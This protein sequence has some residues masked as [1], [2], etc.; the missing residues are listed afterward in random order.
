MHFLPPVQVLY[1]VLPVQYYGLEKWE[2]A[3]HRPFEVF[4]T[5]ESV[6]AHPKQHS[7]DRFYHSVEELPYPLELTGEQDETDEAN[8]LYDEFGDLDEQVMPIIRQAERECGLVE[9][10]R[11]HRDVRVDGRSPHDIFDRTAS[12]LLED[13]RVFS[14]NL[15]YQIRKLLIAEFPL[16]R[17]GLHH[18]PAGDV[19]IEEW[20]MIYP[21]GYLFER[22][23]TH[24]EHASNEDAAICMS[25]DDLTGWL[26]TWKSRMESAFQDKYGDAVK[27]LKYVIDRLPEAVA[28]SNGYPEFIACFDRTSP[29]V[30]Q[31][32]GWLLCPK[33]FRMRGWS[34][35]DNQGKQYQSQSYDGAYNVDEHGG[36]IHG[37]VSDAA[38][39]LVHATIPGDQQDVFLPI[40][41]YDEK[42]NRLD[43]DE[44]MRVPLP[45]EM[46]AM[47]S[48]L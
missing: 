35:C 37:L 8:Q 23:T 31:P 21:D 32:I 3:S 16:W 10:D 47:Q 28:R 39:Q 15:L 29:L 5:V 2:D 1:N 19:N 30:M 44:Y 45:S 41:L 17:V 24:E 27:Q 20:L 11:L 18:Y 25:D 48:L 26:T 46:I 9:T 13:H 42:W 40:C 7:E 14:K 34:F 43:A 38:F 6:R 36:L 12:Y 22:Y 33:Q 4:H